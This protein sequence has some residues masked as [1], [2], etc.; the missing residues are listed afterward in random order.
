MNFEPN[1]EEFLI[2]KK[3]IDYAFSLLT[4]DDLTNIG[5]VEAAMVWED[6]IDLVD[7]KVLR[8][9]ILKECVMNLLERYNVA[10]NQINMVG[11]Q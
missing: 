1:P 10:R 5:I 8:E 4:D 6:F 7:G 2:R 11:D 9:L 3:E